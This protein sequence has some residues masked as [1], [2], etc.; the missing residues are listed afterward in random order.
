MSQALILKNIALF[1]RILNQHKSNT[2]HSEKLIRE[3]SHGHC[4]GFAICHGVMDQM[5]KIAWWEAALQKIANWHDG[6]DIKDTTHL[7]KRLLRLVTLPDSE[8][9]TT[10]LFE[11]FDRVLNYVVSHQIYTDFK[12]ESQFIPSDLTQKTS[13]TLRARYLEYIQNGVIRRVAHHNAKVVDPEL[14]PDILKL[15]LDPNT[16]RFHVCLIASAGHIVRVG[17]TG[18][19]WFIYDPNNCHTEVEQMRAFFSSVDDVITALKHIFTRKEV[20]RIDHFTFDQAHPILF[21]KLAAKFNEELS[22]MH[23]LHLKNT[24]ISRQLPSILSDRLRSYAARQRG[25]ERVARALTRENQANIS[26]L[27]FLIQVALFDPEPLA[28]ALQLAMKS[29]KGTETLIRA[30]AKR[31]LGRSDLH[32]LTEYCPDLAAS[33]FQHLVDTCVDT[34]DLIRS[35]NRKNPRTGQIE[36][37]EIICM[38]SINPD[39]ITSILTFCAKHRDG[40]RLLLTAL[41]FGLLQRLFIAGLHKVFTECAMFQ[42]FE[43]AL[44]APQAAY[45]LMS[46]L[47]ADYQ[48]SPILITLHDKDSFSAV[49]LFKKIATTHENSAAL[50]ECLAIQENSLLT[51]LLPQLTDTEHVELMTLFMRIKHKASPM[52]LRRCLI[53]QNKSGKSGLDTLRMDAPD[54]I[55]AL[56]DLIQPSAEQIPI[57]IALLDHQKFGG[58]ALALL[59]ETMKSSN[60]QEMKLLMQA[61]TA[62]QRLGGYGVHS[63][64]KHAPDLFQS[65]LRYCCHGQEKRTKLLAELVSCL[66]QDDADDKTGLLLLKSEDLKELLE[67]VP[68][69]ISATE[70]LVSFLTQENDYSETHFTFLAQHHADLLQRIMQIFSKHAN[71]QHVLRHLLDKSYVYRSDSPLRRRKRGIDI[72]RDKANNLAIEFEK[73]ASHHPLTNS[74][75]SYAASE[76]AEDSQS[77]MIV[78]DSIISEESDMAG[79]VLRLNAPSGI[80]QRIELS[81][82][83]LGGSPNKAYAISKALVSKYGFNQFPGL[84]LLAQYGSTEA[85]QY[86]RSENKELF[87]IIIDTR[88]VAHTNPDNFMTNALNLKRESHF[89]IAEE[90]LLRN[91]STLCALLSNLLQDKKRFVQLIIF[92]INQFPLCTE[93]LSAALL[94]KIDHQQIAAQL[95]LKYAPKTFFIALSCIAKEQPS[96]KSKPSASDFC[97]N[98]RHYIEILKEHVHKSASPTEVGLFSSKRAVTA[99]LNMATA[100][101]K[102]QRGTVALNY[103]ESE[104][105]TPLRRQISGEFKKFLG[106]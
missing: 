52:L 28:L 75:N 27:H 7:E 23:F 72:L 31:R 21:P 84:Y 54:V 41:K 62:R 2:L 24:D 69:S 15:L 40:N 60:S 5:D 56:L 6:S 38:Q 67:I 11:I 68:E 16:I 101:N 34:S 94:L 66:C 53:G 71:T 12:I 77:S 30:L 49:T 91:P 65:L 103:L 98:R 83:T 80:P 35:L 58:R 102:V 105:D 61:A 96:Q 43:I 86:I 26:G 74:D 29:N 42:L 73:F 100:K 90:L 70:Q 50:L 85:L 81:T 57:Y 97:I 1:I 92:F 10:T 106:K 99:L 33:I 76:S 45:D 79:V 48:G 59:N 25:D 64:I 47:V 104:E 95:L 22:G 87:R 36:M 32:S 51:L 18:T 17:H 14:S 93:Y 20:F 44:T 37:I 9:P 78:F 4:H 39:A 13:L 55:W 82:Q 46:V 88:K 63:I 89:Y 8:T 3:L 19:Q